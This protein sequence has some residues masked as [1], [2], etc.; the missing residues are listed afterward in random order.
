VGYTVQSTVKNIKRKK[1][2]KVLV[3]FFY[4][5]VHTILKDE[6]ERKK[7]MRKKKNNLNQLG[8]PAKSG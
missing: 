4:S 2:L 8:Y 5:G 6:I 3:F 7:L 1:K